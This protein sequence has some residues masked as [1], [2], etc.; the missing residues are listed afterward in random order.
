LIAK[1]AFQIRILE[2]GWLNSDHADHADDDDY[3]LCS[4]GKIELIIGGQI[5]A[6]GREQ[7]GISESAQALLRTLS[8]DH[9]K[10]HPVAER[11]IFHGCG[12]I[13]MMGCP[14]G[15]DWSV[16]HTQGEVI[17]SDVIR[18]KTTNEEH[19]IPQ[20]D[21]TVRVPIENYR[22]Q[23]LYFAQRAK[24]PFEE[25][26]KTF[27]GSWDQAQYDEFWNEYEGHLRRWSDAG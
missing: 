24:L 22:S 16:T 19:G 14:I 5:I 21:L 20:S 26:K 17:I 6:N 23:V 8:A 2:Q 3:D 7:Y 1:S 4:H 15:I 25:T 9:S 10:A 27:T 18:Y 12:L 11:L 13:L